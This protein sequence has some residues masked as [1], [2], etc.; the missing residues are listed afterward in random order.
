MNVIWT[1]EAEQDRL[2]IWDYIASKN[3]LAAIRMDELFSDAV[4][5]LA[6]Y[7]QSG[8]AGI[9]EGTLELNPHKNHRLVYEI[10]DETIWIL[11]LVNA[12]R[13][14]PL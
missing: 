1:P 4:I 11:A 3:R 6:E 8:R 9:V 13:N 10:K 2:I 5:Q 7:P 12:R 14:W